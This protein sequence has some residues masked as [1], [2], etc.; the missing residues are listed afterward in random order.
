MAQLCVCPAGLFGHAVGGSDFQV[1]LYP[2]GRRVAMA[3]CARC[4]TPSHGLQKR[5]LRMLTR[6]WTPSCI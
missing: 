5:A 3:R 2:P 4:I 1:N 6:R